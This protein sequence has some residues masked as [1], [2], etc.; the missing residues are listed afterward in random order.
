MTRKMIE[1]ILFPFKIAASAIA[2]LALVFYTGSALY[3]LYKIVSSK[4]KR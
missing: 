4:L 1:D 2:I 3:A